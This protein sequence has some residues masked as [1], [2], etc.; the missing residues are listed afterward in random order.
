MVIEHKISQYEEIKLWYENA[1]LKSNIGTL[2][3]IRY[4]RLCNN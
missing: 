2:P 1:L 3:D 4:F